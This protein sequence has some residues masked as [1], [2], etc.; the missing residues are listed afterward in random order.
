M[1]CQLRTRGTIKHQ[2]LVLHLCARQQEQQR[3]ESHSHHQGCL[4]VPYTMLLFPKHLL[5]LY[6]QHPMGCVHGCLQSP[7]C[8]HTKT[9]PT[10]VTAGPQRTPTPENL[11]SPIGYTGSDCPLLPTHPANEKPKPS[12][13]QGKITFK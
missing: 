1:L 11:Q 12:Q 9:P 5:P 13:Y 10:E 7:T 6:F 4:S 3:T 8:P 2:A